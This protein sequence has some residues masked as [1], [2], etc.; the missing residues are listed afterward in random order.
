[1]SSAT[2]VVGDIRQLLSQYSDGQ[3]KLGALA[4]QLQGVQQQAEQL[5]LELARGRNTEAQLDSIIGEHHTQIAAEVREANLAAVAGSLLL[6]H[7]PG[8]CCC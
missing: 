6:A 8:A 3:A 4:E 1:M 2:E 5:Q 7:P